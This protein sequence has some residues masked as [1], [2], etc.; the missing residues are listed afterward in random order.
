M[1]LILHT[2]SKWTEECRRQVNFIVT[3]GGDG[4]ILWAS[5]QFNGSYVPPLIT[6][7]QGSLGFLCNFVFEDHKEVMKHVFTSVSSK[8]ESEFLGIDSRMRLKIN[9]GDGN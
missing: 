6:F 5:K 3:L 1:S 8:E 9:M 4:T 2:V 7:D